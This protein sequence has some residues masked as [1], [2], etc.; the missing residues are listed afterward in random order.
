[1]GYR[2]TWDLDYS[3]NHPGINAG[4]L[5]NAITAM[6]A[7]LLSSDMWLWPRPWQRRY[8]HFATL[9]T[10]TELNRLDQ[11]AIG[12]AG[13]RNG[14]DGRGNWPTSGAQRQL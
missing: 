2:T 5:A 10:R 1:M 11:G 8:F 6:D 13:R 14:K 12:Q 3:T 4:P 9:A 7:Y